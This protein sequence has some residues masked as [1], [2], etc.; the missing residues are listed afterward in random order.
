MTLQPEEL[1]NIE[2]FCDCIKAHGGWLNTVRT[3][4]NSSG[5]KWIHI[6]GGYNTHRKIEVSKSW[7]T[8]RAE[9]TPKL[10]ETIKAEIKSRL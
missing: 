3:D 8:N 1:L 7:F 5:V 6:E 10:I 4:T 9:V 2:A